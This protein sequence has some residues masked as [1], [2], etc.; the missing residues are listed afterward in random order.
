MFQVGK[1][2][3][4]KVL[5]L[6]HNKIVS[7]EGLKVISGNKTLTAAFYNVWTREYIKVNDGTRPT[8]T[9]ICYHMHISYITLN[10]FLG[11]QSPHL[12]IPGQ[13]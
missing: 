7:I 10:Y 2:H 3:H 13:Q 8:L 12:A 1:L 9:P 11:S 4:L 6:S 5:D